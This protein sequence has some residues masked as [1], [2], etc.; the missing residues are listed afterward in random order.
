MVSWTASPLYTFSLTP[1]R[2]RSKSPT[3]VARLYKTGPQCRARD[4]RPRY[5]KIC[6]TLG[7]RA[8]PP[9]PPSVPYVRPNI[10]RLLL[11]YRVAGPTLFPFLFSPSP[12][13]LPHFSATGYITPRGWKPK[14]KVGRKIHPRT[15]PLRLRQGKAARRS[16]RRAMLDTSSRWS[17]SPSCH[18]VLY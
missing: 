11:M 7:R 9:P 16:T 17:V 1:G 12:L 13:P 18:V 10:A 15:R 4:G 14:A 6:R 2:D 3:V 8:L 5:K